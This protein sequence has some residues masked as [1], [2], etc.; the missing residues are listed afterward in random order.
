MFL[1]V[2]NVTKSIH[3]DVVIKNVS[4]CSERGRV[5]GLRGINGSGQNDADAPN[6]WIDPP[7]ERTGFDR[8]RSRIERHTVSEILRC[9]D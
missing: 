5:I 9:A 3:G 8:R 2:K 1:E 6:Q 7:H 4:L